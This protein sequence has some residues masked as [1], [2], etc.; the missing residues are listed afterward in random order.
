MYHTEFGFLG[1]HAIWWMF[2]V[3]VAGVAT[4][5]CG[6]TPAAAGLAL[7]HVRCLIRGTQVAKYLT[8]NSRQGENGSTVSDVHVRR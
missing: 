8:L 1:M 6:L 7:T 4:F 5:P 2:L 3:V